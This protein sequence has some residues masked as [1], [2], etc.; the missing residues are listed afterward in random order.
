MP[1][2]IV[3]R[4]AGTNCEQELVRAFQLTGADVELVHIDRLID[5]PDRL[6]EADLIGFP[7][8]FSYGDDIASGRI[9]AMKMRERLWPQLRDA[10]ER[11][12]LMLGVCNGFQVMVQVGLLPGP[13]SGERW[14]DKPPEQTLA[15]AHN[16]GGRFVDRW[17]P[18]RVPQESVC[19]WTA[20]WKSGFANEEL[21]LPS[22]HGEGRV[23]A[24]S[25]ELLDRLEANGQVAV[26]YADNF[27]GSQR[28]IAGICDI[29]GRVFGLMPHPERFLDWTR[30]PFWTRLGERAG[31]TP[32]LAMFQGAAAA[33]SHQSV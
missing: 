4:T 10:A 16:V 8:G 5:V 6:A 17:S 19:V 32:G 33:I 14:P 23:V 11:G 31:P 3:I 30:H 12:T 27:N 7:G 18:V 20:A 2:A 24:A 21:T 1:R 13:A 9:L 25:E 26:C 28:D 22:A 15:L 29:S